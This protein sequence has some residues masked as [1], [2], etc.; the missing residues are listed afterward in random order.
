MPEPITFH[1]Q[2]WRV[3]TDHKGES[4]VAFAIPLS[5]LEKVLTL[6]NYTQKLLTVTVEVEE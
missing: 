5:D 6:G 1:A 3:S 2:L 4:R